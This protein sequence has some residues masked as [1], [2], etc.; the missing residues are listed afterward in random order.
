DIAATKIQSVMRMYLQKR[1]YKYLRDCTEA[2]KRIQRQFRVHLGHTKTRR[3]LAM[4]RDA[5]IAKW[6]GTMSHFLADWGRI[7]NQRRVILH[8][9]SLSYSAFQCQGVPF[10]E[11]MQRAQ[12]PRLMDLI[13]EKVEICFLSPMKF[14]SDAMQYYYN[15][16]A[17][18]GVQQ[19][20]T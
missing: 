12:L 20:E 18:A 14:E 3:T 10:F 4:L 7:K 9:P 19:P 13:D 1:R 15:I 17:M 6:R 5:L 16:L 8:L 11:Q 2:A